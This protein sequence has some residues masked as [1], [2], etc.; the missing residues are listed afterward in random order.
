MLASGLAGALAAPA[1]AA[2]IDVFA[3]AS[4]SDALQ[5]LTATYEK[6]SGDRIALNLG[7]SSALARQI[8]EGAP[9]DLFLSADEEKMNGLDRRHLLVP[10]SRKSV[11]SNTLVIVVP[12]D[13]TL[14]ITSAA[15]LI[16]A[17]VKAIALAEPQSVPAGIY[18]KQYLKAQKL[19]DRVIDKVIPTE[20]V[21]A[22][23]AAVEAGNADAGIVYKS[24]A[25]I[26]KKV[27]VAFQVPRA[28]G[29]QI[30][31]PFAAIASSRHL[32]AARRFLAWLE[33]PEALAVFERYGFL[34]AGS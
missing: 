32:E 10:G 12:S 24:D 13:S 6:K 25:G 19:W 28:A 2:E 34:R 1:R 11:L 16:G 23:L 15:D 30:S 18:A 5:E 7:A 26:S 14:R 8:Q 33:S 3:A 27:K 29:P 9:A 17:Q 21:R 4:L 31:Y 22:A 20:N